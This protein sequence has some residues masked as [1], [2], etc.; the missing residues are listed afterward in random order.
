LSGRLPLSMDHSTPLIAPPTMMTTKPTLLPIRNPPMISSAYSEPIP[1]PRPVTH[2]DYKP[3]PA[4]PTP[5]KN[6]ADPA[7]SGRPDMTA[8]TSG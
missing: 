5:A 2:P 1:V 6:P 7:R 8:R 3:R 4:A